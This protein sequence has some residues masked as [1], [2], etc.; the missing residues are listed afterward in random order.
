MQNSTMFD[1]R[2]YIL[3][4][5]TFPSRPISNE[6]FIH[7]QITGAYIQYTVGIHILWKT[8]KKELQIIEQ[9]NKYQLLSSRD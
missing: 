8:F 2:I 1:T 4:E 5:L 9:S 6:L 7:S 3:R